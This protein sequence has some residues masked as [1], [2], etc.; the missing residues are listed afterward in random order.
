[1]TLDK[2]QM[3][4]TALAA[5]PQK[6]RWLQ[7]WNSSSMTREVLH[8][9]AKGFTEKDFEP[10]LNRASFWAGVSIIHH[11]LYLMFLLLQVLLLNNL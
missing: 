9:P 10:W 2:L 3:I 11:K 5:P 1:M 4:A 8:F 6:V 7:Q